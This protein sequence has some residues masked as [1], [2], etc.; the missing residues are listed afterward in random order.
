METRICL[1]KNLFYKLLD[2]SLQNCQIKENYELKNK[3]VFL[4]FGGPTVNYHNA[5]KRISKE[6]Q[7]LK[8]FD[9]IISLTDLDLKKDT[10]FWKQHGKFLENNKRGYGYWLW[11][12]YLIKKTLEKLN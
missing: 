11:K 4:T 12:S 6:A 5:V 9:E 7:D 2:T 1:S 3:K 8:F 10:V